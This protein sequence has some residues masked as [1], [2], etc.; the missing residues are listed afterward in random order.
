MRAY[1]FLLDTGSLICTRTLTLAHTLLLILPTHRTLGLD[2]NELLCTL[3]GSGALTT[4]ACNAGSWGPGFNCTSCVAG[5]YKA[6]KGS[7]PCTDCP[8]ET[9]RSPTGSVEPSDCTGMCSSGF[10]G[11]PVATPAVPCTPCAAGKFLTTSTANDT[12]QVCGSGKYGVATGQS[13]EASCTA[14][15]AGTYSTAV[16][17]SASSTCSAC[18]S[19]SNSPG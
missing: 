16:G 8:S 1:L 4:C 12:C 9:P 18:P 13:A 15:P 7:A 2:E 19:N 14:C 3:A 5:K 6:S 17:A 10:Y 11:N